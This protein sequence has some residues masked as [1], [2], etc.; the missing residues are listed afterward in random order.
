MRDPNSDRLK[1]SQ[2]PLFDLPWAIISAVVL[3]PTIES[4]IDI[5]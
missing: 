2:D 5:A 1:P 4:A 3:G